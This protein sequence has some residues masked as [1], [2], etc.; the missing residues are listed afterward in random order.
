MILLII[1]SLYLCAANAENTSEAGSLGGVNNGNKDSAMAMLETMRILKEKEARVLITINKDLSTDVISL[2]RG[3]KIKHCESVNDVES[4]SDE[5]KR[6]KCYPVGHNPYGKILKETSIQLR[7]G[8]IC[9]TITVGSRLY[10]VCQPP[11]DL[12]F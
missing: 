6:L 9:A 4:L 7:E 3:E 12:G 8:S 11:V 10:V 5:E 1:I 2:H